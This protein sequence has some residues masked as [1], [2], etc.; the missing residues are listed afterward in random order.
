MGRR[1]RFHGEDVFEHR[2]GRGDIGRRRGGAFA[3]HGFLAS[4][5]VPAEGACIPARGEAVEES[6]E[7]EERFGDEGAV[8]FPHDAADLLRAPLVTRI[9]QLRHVMQENPLLRVIEYF[10]CERTEHAFAEQAAVQGAFPADVVRVDTVELVRRLRRKP[11]QLGRWRRTHAL[12]FHRDGIRCDN[13]P[14]TIRRTAAR[15]P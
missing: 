9:R 7:G 4:P 1:R 11:L 14:D 10:R 12:G 5:H 6:V 8:L 3:A 13:T 15:R 2:H